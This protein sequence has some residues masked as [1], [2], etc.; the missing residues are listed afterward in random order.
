MEEG[1]R[2]PRPDVGL[3]PEEGMTFFTLFQSISRTIARA[4]QN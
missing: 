3:E 1:P 2:E 4:S